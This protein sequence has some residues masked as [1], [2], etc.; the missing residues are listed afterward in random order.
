MTMTRNL[1]DTLMRENGVREDS[2]RENG[3]RMNQFNAF[4]TVCPD[5]L[6][7]PLAKTN[8]GGRSRLALG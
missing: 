3:V 6:F 1:G 5:R 7:G 2:R 8:G 4:R